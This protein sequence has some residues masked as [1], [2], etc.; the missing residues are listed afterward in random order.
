MT[1][2]FTDTAPRQTQSLMPALAGRW[3]YRIASA[4]GTGTL[5]LTL[6]DGDRRTVSGAARGPVAD[7]HFHSWR[8]I[9]RIVTGGDIGFAEGYIH[10][11]WSTSDVAALLELI[12]R[13]DETVEFKAEGTAVRRFV[14]RLYHMLRANTLKGS[15]R[16]IQAHYDLGNGF[17]REWLDPTMTYS[18]GI[19][20]N[21]NDPLEHAQHR[22]YA[23]MAEMIDARPGKHV[24][25]IGCGWGGF[26]AYLAERHGCRVTGVT[27]S[28]EQHAHAREHI[29][30]K[31]LSDR[32]DIRI[33][34]YRD[35]E[36]T[37]DAV[38]SIEM[39]EAVGE[40]NWPRFFAKV[41]H[42]LADHGRAALQVIT[43]HEKRF[44]AY[45]RKTDFIQRYVFPGGM[46]PSVTAF[47]EH[48]ASA[49]LELQDSFFFGESYAQTLAEWQS[50]FSTAWPRINAIGFDENFRRLWEYYL[51]Y[52]RAGFRTG[53]IDVGQFVLRKA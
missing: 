19:Y 49:G 27:L 26:S 5:T 29:A 34:D 14:D 22:K 53:A 45:R 10:G 46:L 21:L 11:D 1:G 7:I 38:A 52:C 40:N 39:F 43:I 36:G 8:A 37:F 15:R 18:S 13:N 3:L 31:G 32:V 44:E 20:E 17:Y 51:A 47:R 9:R 16:N 2:P 50:R 48:A 6:P 28:D 24:L 23:R 35:I 4:I 33:Q 25:E 30:K 41:R 12:A 42:H